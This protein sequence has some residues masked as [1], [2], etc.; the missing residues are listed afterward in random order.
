MQHL[1]VVAEG[2]QFTGSEENLDI[3]SER[4]NQIKQGTIFSD[5]PY[6]TV[7]FHSAACRLNL[8]LIILYDLV[9]C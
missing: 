8:K 1:P 4:T 9:E 6:N 5:P 3:L 7:H 2:Y